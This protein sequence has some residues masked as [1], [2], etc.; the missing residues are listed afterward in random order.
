[1]NMSVRYEERKLS[2]EMYIQPVDLLY[3]FDHRPK[4]NLGKEL[5][6]LG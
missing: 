6:D 5:T 4:V 2:E 1:M 3:V